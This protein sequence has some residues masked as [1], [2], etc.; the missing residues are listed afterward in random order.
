MGHISNAH[1]LPVVHTLPVDP[2]VMSVPHFLTS[3]GQILRLL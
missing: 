2:M 1:M 3:F